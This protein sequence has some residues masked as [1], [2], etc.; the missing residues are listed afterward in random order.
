MLK[1]TV[2]FLKI[3][4]EIGSLSYHILL[5]NTKTAVRSVKTWDEHDE[6]EVF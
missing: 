5:L 3:V 1:K 4:D 6:N 2:H